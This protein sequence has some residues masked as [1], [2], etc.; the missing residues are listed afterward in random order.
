MKTIET[1]KLIKNENEYKEALEKIE[2][3]QDAVPNTPAGDELELLAL[4][5]EKYE[6]EQYPMKDADAINAVEY[7]MEE[8]GFK[9]KDLIGIIGDKSLVSKVMNRERNLTLRMIRNLHDKLGIP[10]ELLIK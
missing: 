4:L 2:H 8:N 10:Y 5:V 6:K 7:Y 1:Y 9:Q 3:L